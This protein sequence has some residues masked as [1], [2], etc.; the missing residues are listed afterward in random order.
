MQGFWCDRRE[1]VSERRG[2]MRKA[3]EVPREGSQVG[4]IEG[5]KAGDLGDK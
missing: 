3:R 4:C 2:F 5:H 1:G